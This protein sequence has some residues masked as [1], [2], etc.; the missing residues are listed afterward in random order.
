MKRIRCK[1]CGQLTAREYGLIILEK[2]IC[3]ECITEILEMAIKEM[4]NETK[5]KIK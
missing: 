2:F 3:D 1:I 5:R 4:Q